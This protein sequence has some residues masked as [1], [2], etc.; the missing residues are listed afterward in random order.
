[1]PLNFISCI[2][3]KLKHIYS[4]DFVELINKAINQKQPFIQFLLISVQ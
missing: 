4:S 1:M 3:N 2:F